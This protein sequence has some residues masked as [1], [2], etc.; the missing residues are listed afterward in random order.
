MV[1]GWEQHVDDYLASLKGDKG[2]PFEYDDFTPEQLAGLVGPPGPPVDL[3]AADAADKVLTST[4]TGAGEYAW[5]TPADPGDPIP[6]PDA[7][8]KVLTSTGTTAGAYDWQ[9]PAAGGIPFNPTS[10]GQ[11]IQSTDGST[12]TAGMSFTIAA[13]KPADSEGNIG[14]VCFV[15]GSA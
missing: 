7:A 6:V 10:V 2:D 12:W 3:P 8:E 14:D 13:A 9:T 5:E 4:G 1:G 15:M 11:V